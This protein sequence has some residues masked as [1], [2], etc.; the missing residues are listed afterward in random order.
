MKPGNLL[1]PEGLGRTNHSY[2][3]WLAFGT[4]AGGCI[5]CNEKLKYLHSEL[6]QQAPTECV[7]ENF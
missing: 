1:A 3:T 6:S 2:C 5:I 7:A 4:K